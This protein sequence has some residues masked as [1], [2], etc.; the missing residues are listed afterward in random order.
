MRSKLVMAVVGTLL[1]AG[2][3]ACG[4]SKASSS[5]GDSSSGDSVAVEAAQGEIV[6]ASTP[7]TFTPPG[8]ALDASKSAGSSIHIVALNLQVPLLAHIAEYAT[9]IGDELDI[10]VAVHNAAN[11]VT[12]MQKGIQDAID[13]DADALLILG[14]P[15]DLV[16]DALAKAKAA[17]IPVINVLNNPIDMDAPGQGAGEE[18]FAA[19]GTDLALG[20]R[21]IAEK[22]IVDTD[23]NANVLFIDSEGLSPQP[24]VSAAVKDTLAACSS[25]T[26]ET[27]NVPVENWGTDITPLVV[28]ALRADPSINYVITLFDSMAIFA[29]AGVQQAGATGKV[30]VVSHNG[31]SAALALVKKGDIMTADP[32]VSEEWAGWA[33]IDQAMRGMQGLEPG[34]PM[35]PYLYLDTASVQDVDIDSERDVYGDS[36]VAGFTALWGLE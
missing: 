35:V 17:G 22:A 33:A 36:F 19:V 3:A 10:N 1:L 8:P 30:H 24:P 29:T 2:V 32:G 27:K 16:R 11:Q 23:G 7:L 9:E 25:C 34:D 31:G 4:D 15:V 18:F 14:V 13:Q 28:T 6:E 12:G 21:L 5:S 26:L 20:G